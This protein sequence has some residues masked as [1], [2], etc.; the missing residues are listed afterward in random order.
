MKANTSLEL[1]CFARA[2]SHIRDSIT[3][4]IE[5]NSH[6]PSMYVGELRP[7]VVNEYIWKIQTCM[8]HRDEVHSLL[9]FFNFDITDEYFSWAENLVIFEGK[10]YY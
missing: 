7:Y 9:K 5:I 6:V 8:E 4:S 1:S 3:I 2:I 10:L